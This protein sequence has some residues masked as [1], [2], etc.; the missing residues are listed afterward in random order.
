MKLIM[1]LY[2]LRKGILEG[3]ALKYFY[4]IHRVGRVEW[5]EPMMPQRQVSTLAV[6]IVITA[7]TSNQNWLFARG[8][9]NAHAYA[10][11]SILAHTHIRSHTYT[12][13]HT[14][15]GLVA[16]RE[17]HTSTH[18]RTPSST[19]HWACV[20]PALSLDV[21]SKREFV[22]DNTRRT[23]QP[24]TFFSRSPSRPLFAAHTSTV[25]P[26]LE[27]SLRCSVFEIDCVEESERDMT[28]T[29]FVLSTALSLIFSPSLSLFLSHVP[30]FPYVDAHSKRYFLI[31]L[32][33]SL[34]RVYHKR[35]PPTRARLKENGRHCRIFSHYTF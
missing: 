6:K 33:L 10:S 34:F 18:K 3:P 25:F 19:Y 16:T 20:S 32:S 30:L 11:T 31:L 15:K 9:V 5:W 13:T 1:K 4:I 7:I 27:R 28:K 2:Q 14:H 8:R 12:H 23:Q 24:T 26:D 21:A 22:K 35:T 29:T 17:T